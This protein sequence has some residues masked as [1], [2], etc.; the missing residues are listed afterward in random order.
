[1]DLKSFFILIRWPNVLLVALMQIILFYGYISPFC[2]AGPDH[3]SFLL[4]V[5]AT[6]AILGG[7]NIDNDIRDIGPDE[8]HPRKHKI[9]G[10]E[11]PLSSARVWYFTLNSL[12]MAAAFL[13][14]I[15]TKNILLTAVFPLAIFLLF[16]YSSKLKNSILTGNILIAALCALAVYI[17]SLLPASCPLNHS[18]LPDQ[19]D[20]V[21]FQ[22]YVLN[23]F[24]ILLLRE[25]I[26]DKEDAPS[27]RE[28]GLRTTGML[29]FLPFSLLFY[30]VMLIIGCVNAYGM[31]ILFPH[32]S[33]L[34]WLTVLLLLYFPLIY[35][36]FI[37][38]SFYKNHYFHRLSFYLKIYIL[39]AILI[40]VLWL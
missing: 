8:I 27:D 35:I 24:F 9:I 21:I 22:G 28:W 1:M 18:F 32:F 26:K 25:M 38:P 17:P 7:G 39:L 19:P 12:A 37:L 3:V 14:L 36:A 10:K 34:K 31:C 33:A 2:A 23:A 15:R 16:L 5:L 6:G 40:L 29:E 20:S 11:I 4:L 30:G 13:I